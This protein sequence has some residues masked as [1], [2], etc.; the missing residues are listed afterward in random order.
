MAAGVRQA[1]L[2]REPGVRQGREAIRDVPT[3]L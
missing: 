1:K 3:Q 2:M